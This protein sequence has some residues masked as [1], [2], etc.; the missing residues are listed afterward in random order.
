M[1]EIAEVETVRN[2]LKKHILNRKISEV[3]VHYK[4]MIESDINTFASDLIDKS[5]IDIK[6]VGKWLIFETEDRYLLSHL[7]MEG[8]FY[9]KDKKEDKGKHEHV[10]ITFYDGGTLRYEDTRKFGRMNL[11]KKEDLMNTESIAKQGLEPGDKNLTSE[12]LLEK[13][14]NKKLPIKSVLLDQ[15]IISGLGNI[16]VNEVLFYAKI[17]PLRSAN[18]L[19]KEECELIT[20][21]A[22]EIIK[23]A[24]KMGGT[25]IKSY[26]SS[27]GVTGLFQ[28]NLKVH[29]R[30][31]EP[32]YVCKTPIK[33]I[34]IGGRSTYFCPKCQK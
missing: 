16:Y 3:K 22:D 30:E 2:T 23:E 28:V 21:G 11:I 17:N 24:I 19:T 32:C 7:R 1:P 18:S 12:Y 25:T 10:T 4:P 27:L 9:L 33:N 5:F 13:F 26:T 15:T 31:A 6:R 29:K 8:K 34:K 20:I 14:K